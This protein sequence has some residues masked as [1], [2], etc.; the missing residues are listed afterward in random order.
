MGPRSF[1]VTEYVANWQGIHDFLFVA[2]SILGHISHSFGDTA[3]Y[4]SKITSGTYPSHLMSSLRVTPCKYVDDFVLPASK[5]C[6][7][8]H[9]FVL[10]R[11]WSVR[12]IANTVQSNAAHCREEY[13]CCINKTAFQL[14]TD[15][16]QTGQTDTIFGSCDLDLDMMTL[17]YE[18]DTD[19]MHTKNKVSGSITGQWE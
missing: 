19:S 7:I 8:L 14:K 16:P 5:H 10:R 12:Q 13:Y 2:N 15:H 18:L 11:Y 9:L 17:T 1:K 6:I 4:W 3:I